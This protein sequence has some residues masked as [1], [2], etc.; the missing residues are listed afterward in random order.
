MTS[1]TTELDSEKDQGD[2]QVA[3]V[4]LTKKARLGRLILDLEDQISRK[5]PELKAIT[6]TLRVFGTAEPEL[7]PVKQL[8]KGVPR[9][10]SEGFRCGELARR[11]LDRIR[12][13]NEPAVSSDIG[14]AIMR[15]C[16][17]DTGDEKL[18]FIF[19]HKVCNVIRQHTFFTAPLVVLPCYAVQ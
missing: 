7:D 8:Q 4:L 12:E 17:M 10:N 9:R 16:L 1:A 15:E 3:A 6:V 5:R 19:Q 2:A 14:R 11:V 13:S 18:Y